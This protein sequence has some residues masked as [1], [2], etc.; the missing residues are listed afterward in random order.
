M[1]QVAVSGIGPH[2][3]GSAPKVV[4]WIQLFIENSA[5]DWNWSPLTVVVIGLLPLVIA[6][7]GVVM[8]VVGKSIFKWFAQEDGFAENLQ[9]LFYLASLGMSLVVIRRQ[10]QSGNRFIAFLYCGLC[11]GLFFLTGEEISW[12]QRIFGWR[13]TGEMAII[14]QQHETNLHNL[15][16]VE[17]VFKWVQLLVGAYGA[18]LPLL[19][20]SWLKPGQLREMAASLIPPVL[21]IPY[22][23]LMFVWKFYRNLWPEPKHFTFFLMKYNEVMELALAMGFFFFLLYQLRRMSQNKKTAAL[24]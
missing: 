12:G 19:I 6:L 23:G 11:L 20:F 21:L 15:R 1:K 5:A 17:D 8:A 7:G 13:T 9:V 16:G 24:Q 2:K 18:L 4:Q 22:F 10:W 3:A 14:N